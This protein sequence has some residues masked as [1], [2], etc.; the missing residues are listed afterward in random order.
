LVIILFDGT[1][2][3]YGSIINDEATYNDYLK[4]KSDLIKIIESLR[5]KNF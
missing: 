2:I 5:L 4:I 3:E 1:K